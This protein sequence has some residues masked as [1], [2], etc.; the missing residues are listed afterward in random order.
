[1]FKKLAAVAALAIAA[2]S[3]QAAPVVFGDTVKFD[4]KVNG[5]T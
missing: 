3:A 4:L 2:S 1:M 5:N